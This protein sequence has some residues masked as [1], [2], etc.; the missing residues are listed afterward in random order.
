M[1]NLDG[2]SRILKS[3]DS[4]VIAYNIAGVEW[5]ECNIFLIYK[6]KSGRGFITQVHKFTE[7]QEHS[8]KCITDVRKQY[9]VTIKRNFNFS[10]CEN[11]YVFTSLD[12]YHL[13]KSN[14]F[15]FPNEDMY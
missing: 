6:T 1:R 15:N 14:Q 8:I 5:K 4:I 11:S 7:P 13:Y 2:V 10:Q 12:D 9:I 3:T